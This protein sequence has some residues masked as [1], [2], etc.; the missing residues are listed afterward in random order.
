MDI[1]KAY[2]I[3]YDT[4]TNKVERGVYNVWNELLTINKDGFMLFGYNFMFRDN[5]QV[6]EIEPGFYTICRFD[7]PLTEQDNML[8]SNTI[9][10]NLMSEQARINEKLE[11]LRSWNN[12]FSKRS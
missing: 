9:Y 5:G 6:R 4:R 3:W 2:I 12:E 11:R 8:L 7:S 1:K 10:F